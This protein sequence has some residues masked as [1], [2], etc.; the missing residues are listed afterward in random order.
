MTIWEI[1]NLFLIYRRGH[2]NHFAWRQYVLRHVLPRVLFFFLA[3]LIDRHLISVSLSCDIQVLSYPKASKTKKLKQRCHFGNDPSSGTLASYLFYVY[4]STWLHQSGS[5]R[6]RFV[7]I[8]AVIGLTKGQW[9]KNYTEKK[10]PDIIQEYILA[11]LWSHFWF[12]Q[13]QTSKFTE[14]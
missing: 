11:G 3:E 14:K 6:P 4:N 7:I 5:G 1:I 2:R 9:V 12:Q 8:A 10:L 13:V